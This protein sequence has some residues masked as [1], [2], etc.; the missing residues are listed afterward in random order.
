[1]YVCMYVLNFM[2][3]MDNLVHDYVC[4]MRS[5]DSITQSLLVQSDVT[6]TQQAIEAFQMLQVILG[7]KPIQVNT[8]STVCI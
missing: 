2:Y 3:V 4:T 8:L 1:M 6:L 5:S 7:E